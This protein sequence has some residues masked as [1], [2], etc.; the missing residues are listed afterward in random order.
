MN[1]FALD[2]S[3]LTPFAPTTLAYAR[4]CV[5]EAWVFA[6]PDRSSARQTQ[7]TYGE[8]LR[9]IAVQGD[10]LYAQSLYDDYCG[11]LACRDVIQ[12]SA[13]PAADSHCTRYSAPITA[14]A[15]LKSTPL[16]LLPPDATFTPDAEDGDY[17]HIANLGWIHRAHAMPRDEVIDP[18]RTARELLGKSYVWGGRSVAGLDCS[19]LA[20]LCYR[21]AGRAIPRDADLQ[22]QYLQ[23]HHRSIALHDIQA[24]DLIYIPGHVMIAVDGAHVIHAS[25]QHMRVVTEALQDAVLRYRQRLQAR[26]HIH[27]YRWSA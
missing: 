3:R 19:A 14:A 20:Q 22:A 24:A 7:Y 5:P 13:Q 10:W 27:A 12:Y 15:D 26:Y 9:I 25:G 4:V 21:R 11:W 16:C 2:D 18:V 1:R 6:H 23:H 17:W 8:A